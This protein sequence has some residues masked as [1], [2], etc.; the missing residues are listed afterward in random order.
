MKKTLQ[1]DS[2]DYSANRLKGKIQKLLTELVFRL[3]NL[4]Y[5]LIEEF[6]LDT[7][8]LFIEK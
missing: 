4:F 2:Q 1:Q 5:Y 3:L 8:V 6:S 7:Q